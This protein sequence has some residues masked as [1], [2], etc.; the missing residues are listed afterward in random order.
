M[1]ALIEA[2]HEINEELYSSLITP[3]QA[4]AKQICAITESANTALFEWI[5]GQDGWDGDDPLTPKRWS[6]DTRERHG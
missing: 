4:L 6:F 1:K 5:Q 3:R 2:L